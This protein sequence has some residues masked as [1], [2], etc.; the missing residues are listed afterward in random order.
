[1]LAGTKLELK[2]KE[3]ILMKYSVSVFLIVLIHSC[4]AQ[5]VDI[6]KSIIKAVKEG[7]LEVLES[8]LSEGNDVN[9]YYGKNKD[10]T[11]LYIAVDSR[12]YEVVKF[13]VRHGTDIEKRSQ[14]LS[15]LMEAAINNQLEICHFLLDQEAEVDAADPAGNTALFYAAKYGSLRLNKLLVQRGADVNMVN[16]RK[17]K[18]LDFAVSANKDTVSVYLKTMMIKK[19]SSVS[20]PDYIDGPHVLW[21]HQPGIYIVYFY[22]D[23][24]TNQTLFVDKRIEPADSVI[25]FQGFK[26]DT[27]EYTVYKNIL[28]EGNKFDGVDRIFV[29]GDLH[30]QY[31]TLVNALVINGVI[32]HDLN[33]QWGNGHLVFIGDILDRGDKVTECLWLIYKL[34]RQARDSGGYVHYILGNHEIMNM[35]DDLRYLP[36]KYQ[37]FCKYFD[38]HYPRFYSP[39]SVLGRW[40]RSKNTMVRI[41]DILFVH[42]G[43]SSQVLAL[44]MDIDT[45]NLIV[46]KYLNLEYDPYNRERLNLL[47]FTFGPFWYRG[48]FAHGNLPPEVTQDQIDRILEFYQVSQMVIGHTDVKYIVPMFEKKIIPIDIPFQDAEYHQ[49]SLLIENGSFYRIYPDGKKVQI[50]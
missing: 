3:K 23:S 25:H 4:F 40:L 8:F 6:E 34:E 31:D 16:K 42:G 32:D 48:Y 13:L 7:D 18:P 17:W 2:L 29:I 30:G 26:L 49:Q 21:D 50:K 24:A 36:E 35:T 45:V 10:K 28:H 38:L 15:P 37:Y 20:I 43:I 5:P 1:M 19:D 22:R 39:E 44:R 27:A 33:W 9:G 12:E 41:N 11:L 47:L 14:D 46:R